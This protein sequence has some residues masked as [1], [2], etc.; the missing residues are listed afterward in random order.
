MKL[1]LRYALRADCPLTGLLAQLH[2]LKRRKHTDALFGMSGPQHR[3]L[4]PLERSA[5]L[6]G[7]EQERLPSN[8]PFRNRR[9]IVVY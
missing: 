6:L 2:S 3:I 8:I 9:A 1:D 5:A 4:R 7:G